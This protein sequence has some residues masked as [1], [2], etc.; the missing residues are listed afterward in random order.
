MNRRTSGVFNDATVVAL[1][2]YE[3][4]GGVNYIG[5]LLLLLSDYSEKIIFLL[6][7]NALT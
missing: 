1:R 3:F 7:Y 2:F 4:H 5:L 6:I